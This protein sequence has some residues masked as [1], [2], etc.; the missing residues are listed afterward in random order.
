MLFENLFK[1]GQGPVPGMDQ[2]WIHVLSR[3]VS[4]SWQGIES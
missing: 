4:K 2:L 3:N 1:M